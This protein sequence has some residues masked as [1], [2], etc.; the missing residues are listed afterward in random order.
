MFWLP[1]TLYTREIATAARGARVKVA[2]D[3]V[4]SAFMT[5]SP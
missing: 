2:E 5:I 3:R 1:K 4:L